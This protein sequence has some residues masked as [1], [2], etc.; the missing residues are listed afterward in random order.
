MAKPTKKRGLLHNLQGQTANFANLLKNSRLAALAVARR[1]RKVFNKRN[2]MENAQEEQKPIDSRCLTQQEQRAIKRVK[3][4]QIANQSNIFRAVD[5]DESNSL[6]LA[7]DNSLVHAEAVDLLDS[8]ILMATGSANSTIGLQLLTNLGKAIIPPNAKG[9][10][11]ASQLNT[12]AQSMQAFAPQDEYEGQLVAQLVIL[13]EHAMNWLGRAM[14]TERVDFS[15]VYLNGASKLLTR[16][17]ETLDALLKYRRKGEQRVHVEH[18]HVHNG[19]QAIVGNITS[20]S[21]MKQ[22]VVEGP[23]AKV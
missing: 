10:E 4:K 23:H 15:N 5:A 8:H 14:R 22:E 18:V 20:G 16:H 9:K 7:L 1:R 12:I 19:G 21:G 17:H 2:F 13:H 6:G 11:I 3:Q